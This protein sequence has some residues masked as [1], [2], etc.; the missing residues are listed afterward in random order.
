MTRFKNL[1]CADCKAIRARRSHASGFWVWV[2]AGNTLASTKCDSRTKAENCSVRNPV[3]LYR[4][5]NSREAYE[6][7]AI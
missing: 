6:N 1:A 4:R 5:P 3:R 2:A 7:T